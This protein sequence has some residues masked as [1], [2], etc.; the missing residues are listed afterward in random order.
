MADILFV[1]LDAGGNVAPALSIGQE[2][3]RRGHRVRV[4]SHEAQRMP[5]KEAGLEFRAYQNSPEWAP[6]E[7]R[8]TLGA[9]RSYIAELTDR[10][11]GDDLSE[12]VR[13]DPADFVVVDC[14]LLNA[15]DAAARAGVRHGA[16]FHTFL[17]Y[18]DGPWRRGPIGIAGRLKGLGPR[19]LWRQADLG[20]VCTDRGLDPAA[21]GTVPEQLTWTGVVQRAEEPAAA[22]SPPRVLASLSTISFPG[23][24]DVL[25]NVLKAVDGMDLELVVTTG[26]AVD[27]ESLPAP[28]NATV[29]RFVPHDDV[30]PGC[31]LVIGHGG[32][33]TTTRALSYDLPMLIVPMHPMLDQPMIGKVVAAAGAGLV[34]G[35]KSSPESIR[36]A[37]KKLLNSEQYRVAARGIGERIRSTNGA[38]VAA[39]RI[40]ASIEATNRA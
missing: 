24:R 2:L 38:S 40:L 39:D 12:L 18:F 21:G 22:Q 11:I 30:M 29:V 33:S 16:L 34:L 23:Q 9:L 19:R 32:H 4:L 6:T 14:M 5:V 28:S 36:D 3:L 25:Q 17:A 20:L 31:S 10:R 35:R 26:P 15:L 7:E 13:T 27:P 37:L 8:K 1:T